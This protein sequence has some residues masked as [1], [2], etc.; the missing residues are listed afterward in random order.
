MINNAKNNIASLFTSVGCSLYVVNQ[1]N[2]QLLSAVI[3]NRDF[4]P[5]SKIT[6]EHGLPFLLILN[7][8]CFKSMGFSPNDMIHL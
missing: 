8:L 5:P 6:R 3:K 2:V 4:Q 7:S 1:V